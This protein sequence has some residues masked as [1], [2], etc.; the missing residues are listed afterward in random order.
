MPLVTR[1]GDSTSGICCG[2]C[3]FC[4]HGRHGVNATCSPNV[5]ANFRGVHRLGD[6]GPCHCPHGGK[7]SSTR[8]SKTVRANFLGV[9]RLG[10]RTNCMKCGCPGGHTSGSPNVIA[11]G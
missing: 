8:A 2:G 11:G 1:K 7:F 4:P 9:T 5:R 10:D 3:K 6:I